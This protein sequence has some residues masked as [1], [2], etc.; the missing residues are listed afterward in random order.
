[1]VVYTNHQFQKNAIEFDGTYDIHM[2][3]PQVKAYDIFRWGFRKKE[4]VFT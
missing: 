2:A 3:S 1:M 4:G